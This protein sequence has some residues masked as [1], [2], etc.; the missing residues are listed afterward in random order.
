MKGEN[1]EFFKEFLFKLRN[2]VQQRINY[3]RS[4]V[5]EKP[6]DSEIGGG[7]PFHMA[8]RGTESMEREKDAL[9]LSREENYL[10]QIDEA[11]N[12]IDM[13]DYGICQNCGK[14]ISHKRLRVVPTTQFCGEC[15]KKQTF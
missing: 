3:L 2:D 6:A 4:L 15:A 12:R 13:G 14:D 11:L 5:Q 9:L 10:Q 7:Y 1:L 8:D